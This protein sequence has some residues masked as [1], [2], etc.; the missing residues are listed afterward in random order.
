VSEQVIQL[1][2]CDGSPQGDDD[3][4]WSKRRTKLVRLTWREDEELKSRIMALCDE[5]RLEL[6]RRLDTTID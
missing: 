6:V 1:Y 5:H 2:Q 4:H 3:R